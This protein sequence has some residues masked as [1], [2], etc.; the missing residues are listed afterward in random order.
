MII[1]TEQRQRGRNI[2][3]MFKNSKKIIKLSQYIFCSIIL[4]L[5]SFNSVLAEIDIKDLKEEKFGLNPLA[6]KI[7]F[8]TDKTATP[9]Q[10]LGQIVGV[11]LSLLGIIFL[12]LM[13]Y[14]GFTW[15]T[16]RGDEQKVTNAKD[17][18]IN[19]AIGAIIVFSAYVI[20]SY[21][22]TFL[23]QHAAKTIPA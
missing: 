2:R 11:A 3:T 23:S 5:I 12:V 1:Y 14:G 9:A 16:A 7:G 22:I 10:M 15:M 18:I 8:Q 20:S 21:I 13:I 17:V 6:K 4:L 19:A